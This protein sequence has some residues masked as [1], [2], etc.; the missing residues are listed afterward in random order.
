MQFSYLVFQPQTDR[1]DLFC[2]EREPCVTS[3]VLLLTVYAT[4]AIAKK[5]S[6]VCVMFLICDIKVGKEEGEC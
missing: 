4:L 5:S 6:F 2:Q 3:L 1:C